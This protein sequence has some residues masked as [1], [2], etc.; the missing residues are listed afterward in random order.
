MSQARAPYRASYSHSP[1]RLQQ[2]KAENAQTVTHL[3]AISRR[4]VQWINKLAAKVGHL[5]SV[6][7]IPISSQPPGSKGGKVY[8]LGSYR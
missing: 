8:N 5:V 2:I 4:K 1:Q 7:V 3:M 6:M